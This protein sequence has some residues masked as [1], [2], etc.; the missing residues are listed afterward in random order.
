MGARACCLLIALATSGC[1][2]ELFVASVSR[3]LHENHSEVFEHSCMP[4]FDEESSGTGF[5]FGAAPADGSTG[6]A[7]DVQVERRVVG[8]ELQVRVTSGGVTLRAR[9][10]GRGFFESGKLDSFTIMMRSGRRFEFL[11][12]GGHDCDSIELFTGE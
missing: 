2:S 10:Y 12:Q 3:E 7:E 8:D 6:F 11:H 9:G 5:G 4:A 1:S